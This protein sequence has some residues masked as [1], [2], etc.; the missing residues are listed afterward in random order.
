M[1][2]GCPREVTGHLP[3]RTGDTDGFPGGGDGGGG[4]V[5][6]GGVG[7]GGGSGVGGGG[8]GACRPLHFP[9]PYLGCKLVLP[10]QGMHRNITHSF[11]TRTARGSHV[12]QRA[13]RVRAPAPACCPRVCRAPAVRAVLAARGCATAATGLLNPMLQWQH[14]LWFPAL[15]LVPNIVFGKKQ[16]WC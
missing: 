5:G 10:T 12:N 3:P 7:G 9:C 13:A 4:G 1:S 2:K 8:A 16:N 6:V 15:F 11:F 14:F